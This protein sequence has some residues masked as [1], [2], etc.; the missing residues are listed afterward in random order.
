[1]KVQLAKHLNIMK[2]QEK[3]AEAR[4]VVVICTHATFV[5]NIASLTERQSATN[6]NYMMKEIWKL[7]DDCEVL[8][9][10]DKSSRL[11]YKT[12][13]K[14]MGGFAAEIQILKEKNYLYLF[15]SVKE[16]MKEIPE[17]KYFVFVLST[18]G[19]DKPEVKLHD[20]SE[21]EFHDKGN[22]HHRHYFYTKDGQFETQK[23]M[24]KI[25]GID[26]EK[27]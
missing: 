8:A 12:R 18:H 13:R 25:N 26:R 14:E 5:K 23:L 11:R 24:T 22:L 20:K 6:D 10:E 3:Q 21:D 16:K 2:I 27:N 7:Y 19:E 1:M 15:A 9:F 17:I 4:G